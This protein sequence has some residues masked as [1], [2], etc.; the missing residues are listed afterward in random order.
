MRRI[1]IVFGLTAATMLFIFHSADWYATN[2]ALPRY[3]NNPDETVAI[4]RKILTSDTPVENQKKR[5]FIIAAKLIF[6]VPQEDGETVEQ[7]IPRLRNRISETCGT[8]Y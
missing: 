1:L 4:V 7:Y 8:T 5:P 6:L 3:C 2:S